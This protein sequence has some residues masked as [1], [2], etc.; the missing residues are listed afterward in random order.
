MDQFEKFDAIGLWE[1]QVRKQNIDRRVFQN[2]QGFLG[3]GYRSSL[4]TALLGHGGAGLA[5]GMFIVHNE[6]IHWCNFAAHCG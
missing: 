5:D 6:E 2:L 1:F 4:H 3:S